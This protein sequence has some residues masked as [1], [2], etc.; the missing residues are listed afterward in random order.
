MRVEGDNN[1][2]IIAGRDVNYINVTP[3]VVAE[4]LRILISDSKKHY[5][6]AFLETFGESEIIKKA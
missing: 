2:I 5:D 4:A 3:E 6:V 1:Q